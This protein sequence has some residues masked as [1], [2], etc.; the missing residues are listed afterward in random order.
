MFNFTWKT[1][2]K[3]MAKVLKLVGGVPSSKLN[4]PP[5]SCIP[6]RANISM[7]KKRRNSSEMMDLIELSREITRFLSDDQYLVTLNIL[8]SLS[9]LNT[10]NPNDPPLTSDHMTS[11]MDPDM[12]TQSKRLKADSK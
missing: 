12:T 10:D 11:N 4:S 3:A 7:N 1:V 5:N 8:K 6:N 9:A 2:S